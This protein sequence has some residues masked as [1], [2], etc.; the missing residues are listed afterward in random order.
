ME[1][2]VTVVPLSLFNGLIYPKIT[3]GLLSVYLVGRVMFTSGYQ[4]KEGAFNQMRI[5]GSV[6]VNLSHIVTL[7]L[8]GFIGF[9]MVRGSLCL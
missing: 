8:T 4:E 3:I 5:T 1:H 6:M 2:L 9:K 7:G